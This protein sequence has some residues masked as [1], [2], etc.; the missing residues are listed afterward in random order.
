MGVIWGANAPDPAPARTRTNSSKRDSGTPRNAREGDE[1][2]PDFHLPEFDPKKLLASAGL[3]QHEVR[4]FLVDLKAGPKPIH[5]TAAFINALHRDGKL[6]GRITEWRDERDLA[7]EAASRPAKSQRV[8]AH[9]D[10]V[11]QFA[12][13]E[14]AE[15][16]LPFRQITEGA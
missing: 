4:D 8:A 1:P 9:A 14:A 7:T 6:P 11:Q 2:P 12:A 15:N 13:Q 5:N 10:L 3:G 16:V